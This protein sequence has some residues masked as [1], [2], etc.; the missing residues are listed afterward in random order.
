MTQLGKGPVAAL[1]A[2][3]IAADRPV[4]AG[5]VL[6]VLAGNLDG[7]IFRCAI[8]AEWTLHFVSSGCEVL[9]GFSAEELVHRRT[10]SLE[11]LTHPDDRL[12]VRQH[13]TAALARGERYRV[14][15]RIQRKDGSTCWVHERGAAV[16]D[17]QGETVLEGFIEDIS[18]W[19]STFARLEE[20]EL[21]YRSIFENSEVGMYQTSEEGHYLAANH[22]LARLYGYESPQA[23]IDSL[24]D[25]A[26]ALYVDPRRR[27]QFKRL[28]EADGVV[29]DFESEVRC[30][31]GRRIWISEN[32]HAVH[33]ADGSFRYY[34]GT[35]ED[36][37]ERRRYQRQLEHQASR[38]A[39]TG[40]PNRSL[41]Q[42]R[43]DHSI[44]RAN[45]NGEQLAVLFIDLDNFKVI[46]DSLGHAAGD[47]LI[48]EM[49]HRL[50]HCVR[51]CDT[52]ARYGGDE[53]VLILEG[54]R[55]EDEV[56]QMLERIQHVVALPM[57][58]SGHALQVSC[59]MGVAVYP[60]HG[61]DLDTLLRH[62]DA[63]MYQ[64]KGER[65][66]SYR[67]YT[68]HLNEAA[69]ER[70][71]LESALHR[72]LP[73][74]EIRVAYQPK[75]DAVG[76]VSGCEAL[77]RWHSL[78]VGEVPPDRF[79]PLAEETGLILPLTEHV[80]RAACRQAA[81]WR[82]QGL[83]C[84]SVAVNL[85]AAQ[86]REKDLVR[87]VT[88]VLRETGLPPE[89]LELEITEHSLVADVD[90]AAATLRALK[91]IGVSI[92][93]DDFGTGYSSL[94]YL[95]RF[96]VDT[97]KIDKSFVMACDRE[98]DARAIA[99]AVI[100]LGHSLGMRVVAEGVETA[101]Q[102]SILVAAG[103]DEFQGYLFSRPLP[104]Q[105]L[106]EYLRAAGH[107]AVREVWARPPLA[108]MA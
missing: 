59:S 73:Q 74:D 46:N 1:P 38:D 75:V 71:R 65:K 36:V 97:L 19:V 92:A 98:D 64:A 99:R 11:T 26:S 33:A 86:F 60:A 87:R 13:I 2:N 85:S 67:F 48:V 32:A 72:A 77:M 8:D 37:S 105:A 89:Q 104:P 18:E 10:V 93:L 16:S 29:R 47:E 49:A 83:G 6:G 44:A 28:I 68:A 81:A 88:E 17:E 107:S 27:A 96:P 102:F 55:R 15:Y 42:D 4:D 103:C 31:D 40:L 9:T 25:I 14:E 61:H 94:A 76:R 45:R 12:R 22:A 54:L 41:L 57:P 82:A 108:R 3:A 58:L 90:R 21:R 70:L 23:L 20:A 52:V 5:R 56:V 35:V 51:D 62:A 91:E 80:L 95:K 79:I 39:L 24:S 53:F 100:S 50:K 63:A 43:L 106:H 34:E 7:M 66:G 84:A 101:E 30:H 69:Q 78:E